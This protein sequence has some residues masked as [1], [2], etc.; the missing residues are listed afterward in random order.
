VVMLT[1]GPGD[2]AGSLGVLAGG[3]A[4]GGECVPVAVLAGAGLGMD[5]W[6]G[7]GS[8]SVRSM[9]GSEAGLLG[10]EEEGVA[11]GAEG[12]PVLSV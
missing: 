6:V 8:E 2:D 4:D 3:E 7:G 5:G 9:T 1:V 10:D 12:E 11:G